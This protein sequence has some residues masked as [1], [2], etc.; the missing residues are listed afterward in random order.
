MWTAETS[1]TIWKY[2]VIKT[3]MSANENAH[4]TAAARLSR[5]K[6]KGKDSTEM[7]RRRMEVNVELRKAKKDDQLLKRRN[8]STFH[9]EATSPLQE[10]RSNQVTAH[11]SVEEIVKGIYGNNT[12]IQ[13]QATQAA[14]K[15]LSRE[16][17]PP[18]DQ[19]I[20]AGLIPKLVSFLGRVDC[21][22]IQFESAWALTNIASGTS[23]QTK[24]VVD[25]GAIPAFVSLLASS[26]THIRE[27]AVWALG[28]IAGDGSAYRDLV[29]KYGALDPLLALLAV[30]DLSSIALGYLRN[31]TWTI[32]N[33]CRNKNPAPPLDAVEQILP[34]LVRLLHHH[35]PEVLADTCWAVSY[36]TDGSNDR[37]E[38]VVKTGLVPQLV[39]LLGGGEIPI[40]T[41][42]L[43]AIGNIVTGTDEQTQVVI[44]S[45][46]L[47]AFPGL[48]T[49]HKNN[50][51]KEAAWTM[52][53]ITAGR[54][55]QIQMVVDHGLV[56]YLINILKK[57]DFKSQKEAVWAVT[58]YTSG[59]TIGQIIYLV[60][61]GVL[62][63][64]LNLL[65]VKDGKTVLVI[66]DAIT[67]IFMASEKINETEK[68]CIMIEECGGLD[69]I[70]ALQS[71]ENE[72]VYKVAANLIEKYFS[73]ED[74]EDGTVVPESSSDA[75]TF[76]IQDGADTFNF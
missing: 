74:E 65:V 12:E 68:L 39:K 75:Y 63:P 54:Q 29:I 72:D 11:W 23:D 30:P 40:M 10:N 51:Q 1:Q 24:A 9:D 21:S 71:H 49:H 8:V 20:Q 13:L 70:E 58:N 64:L 56:P 14:R 7:R 73:S 76:Q 28:N 62:E 15:L 44:D 33:L 36:L 18:I 4:G 19:I 67:N 59:G 6:N 53:N 52:S 50:I 61:A 22:P 45:G 42:S 35:D 3:T 41:P 16:K 25:G 38:M 48:L 2:S 37:I 47:A 46:A 34:T 32:S 69:K 27:Q 66:L 57:G 26:H 55:N 5:F 43:R 31:V 17:Q 60:Q